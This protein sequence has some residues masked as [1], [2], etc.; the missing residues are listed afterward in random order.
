[1]FQRTYYKLFKTKRNKLC[2]PKVNI[3]LVQDKKKLSS[4]ECKQSI[5]HKTPPSHTSPGACGRRVR[6]RLQRGSVVSTIKR[7]PESSRNYLSVP[8]RLKMCGNSGN[9][10]NNTNDTWYYVIKFAL[11]TY[12]FFWLVS[13]VPT[14]FILRR[15][16]AL[17]VECGGGV[18]MLNFKLL[19]SSTFCMVFIL[20][21]DFFT[22]VFKN[23]N[24]LGM[25]LD[26]V[27]RFCRF[28]LQV[29]HLWTHHPSFCSINVNSVTV[30]Q[31]TV[32]Q[33]VPN[34]PKTNP[35]NC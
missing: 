13:K 15:T 30:H 20:P 4:C 6:R 10:S 9:G 19:L 8:P 25:R 22:C 35:K 11:F 18:C 16:G 14:F 32:N 26:G 34:R 21:I 33:L 23:M 1:M 3:F 29:L 17:V 24:E 7:A 31:R 2:Y 27:S 5:S 28:M 12:C